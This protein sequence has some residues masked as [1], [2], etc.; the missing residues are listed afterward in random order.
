MAYSGR[1]RTGSKGSGRLDA[2]SARRLGIIVLLL[3]VIVGAWVYRVAGSE[4]VSRYLETTDAIQEKR[5]TAVDE[6]NTVVAEF[7]G[8]PT[9]A[10]ATADAF[11]QQQEQFQAIRK[12]LAAEDAP[13]AAEDYRIAL[14]ET[15][16][17]YV[18]WCEELARVAGYIELRGEILTSLSVAITEF[19]SRVTAAGSNDDVIA[20]SRALKDAADRAL[21]GIQ[22]LERP[23]L[24]SYSSD[25]LEANVADLASASARLGAGVE[26]LDAGAVSAAATDLRD[27]LARDWAL[28]VQ[29]TDLEG[30]T[31]YTE[32]QVSIAEK[33]E[34]ALTARSR[35]VTQR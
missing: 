30:S 28:A 4:R 9:S 35:L 15:Y 22:S 19:D 13:L 27:V 14:D 1:T 24:L 20:A 6:L 12:D 5:A 2:V 23:D 8:E 7:S 18:A 17:S 33:E 26:S 31:R 32:A 16:Q 25:K 10:A 21:G 29:E 34:A 3:A 11:R